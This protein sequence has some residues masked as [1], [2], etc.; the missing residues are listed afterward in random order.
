MDLYNSH[1]LKIENK[2]IV[3]YEFLS[4]LRKVLAE[5]KLAV[6]CYY[7]LMQKKKKK[8]RN[9][10]IVSDHKKGKVIIKK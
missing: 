3:L 5:K 7:L 1:D 10:I 4:M 6:F 9:P 2:K 8:E